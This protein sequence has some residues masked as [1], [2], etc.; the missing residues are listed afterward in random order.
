MNAPDQ[1]AA[2]E[3]MAHHASPSFYNTLAW[4]WFMAFTVAANGVLLWYIF[5]STLIQ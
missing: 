4:W 5:G 3:R 2:L 1:L